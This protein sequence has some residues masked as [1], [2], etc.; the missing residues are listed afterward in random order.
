MKPVRSTACAGL[1]LLAFA[2][3]V[4]CESSLEPNCPSCDSSDGLAFVGSERCA[5]CH[6]DVASL[7][8]Q[9]GHAYKLNRVSN[10]QVPFYPFRDQV[11]FP[12]QS[13]PAG[14]SWNDVI[15]VIGGYGWKA[16]FIRPDGYILT[17]SDVQ[18]NLETGGWVAYHDGET[19][20]Y[21]CGRCHT[22]GYIPAGNQL[23]LEGLVGTWA[24]DSIGCEACHGAGSAHVAS[25]LAADIVVDRSSAQCG[26]C[27]MRDPDHRILAGSPDSEGAQFIRHHEQ[28][29][30]MLGKDEAG[31]PL[32]AHR[33]LTCVSCH[34]PHVSSKFQA[35]E[36]GI[37]LDCETCH[38]IEIYNTG[39]GAHTCVRC[40]MPF[41]S[42][43]A[44]K[45]GPYEGDVRT[46][47][48]GLETDAAAEMF[49]QDGGTWF[50][51]PF[52]TLDFACLQCHADRD[53]EWAE[54][55]AGTIHSSDLKQ[56]VR[57]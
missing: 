3:L 54:E 7:H 4:G 41:A 21:D 42:K 32:G 53:R 44:V 25:R 50:A 57:R 56:L 51:R 1:L 10:G 11:A 29:D 8:S 45:R 43:S 27:H 52:V 19:K 31:Q 14:T 18:F 26:S 37:V 2:V 55:Y 36:G 23:D 13:P 16:R 30:E 15:Y 28:Y 34:N 17:G 47:V 38:Q 9:S 46:H 33:N 5:T 35:D 39:S 6:G 20:P 48:F 24:E 12:L 22:T 40:H 49:Y